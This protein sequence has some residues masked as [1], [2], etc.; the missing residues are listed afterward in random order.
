VTR[1]EKIALCRTLRDEE[2]LSVR[3]IVRR[4][5]IPR[6]TVGDYLLGREHKREVIARR[7]PPCG[8]CGGPL[9]S[10]SSRA[11]NEMCRACRSAEAHER[12]L[13]V[14]AWWNEGQSMGFIASEM[15]WTASHLS[16][17]MVHYREQGYNLPYRYTTGK[18][19]GRKYPEQVAA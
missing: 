9:L 5:G 7:N 12:A 14:E 2:G 1:E 8:R 4:T 15:G 19:A 11:A 16:R 10:T 13:R 18:R 3:Q 17:M 6:A